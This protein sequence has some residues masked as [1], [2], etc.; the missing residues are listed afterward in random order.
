MENQ[1]DEEVK[2]D[3]IGRLIEL[4]NEILEEQNQKFVGTVQKVLVEG[5]SKTNPE[6]LTGRV[7]SGKVV[8]FA[9]DDAL[10]GNVIDL[11][12]TEQRKWYLTGVLA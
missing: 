3:R 11:K 7:E 2:K 4:V 10:I 12:I 1:I 9:G 5:R 6:M 8:N